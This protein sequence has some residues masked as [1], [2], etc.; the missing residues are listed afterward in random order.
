MMSWT[1]FVGDSVRAEHA[2]A[3]CDLR[4]RWWSPRRRHRPRRGSC[5]GRSWCRRPA[6]GFPR[7][8]LTERPPGT[9]RR[10]RRSALPR[11]RRSAPAARPGCLAEQVHRHDRLGAVGDRPFDSSGVDQ[12]VLL[13]HVH[14]HRRRADP[15]DRFGG[16]DEGVCRQDHLTAGSHVRPHGAPAPAR[17]CRWRLPR[18]A[19]RRRVRRTPA[20]RAS[21]PRRR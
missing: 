7:V 14:Q 10:P 19:R 3:F 15:G 16:G 12:Q 8:V 17:R 6:R 2:H 18:S 13:V 11:H 5:P 1:Y 21:P 20:R 4:R 9:V